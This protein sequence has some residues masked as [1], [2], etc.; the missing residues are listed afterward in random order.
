MNGED[1]R[2]QAKAKDPVREEAG[3]HPPPSPPAAR[4]RR[5]VKPPPN[6]ITAGGVDMARG[7][8]SGIVP[9]SGGS[10]EPV[11]NQPRVVLTVDTDMRRAPTHKGIVVERALRERGP[12]S[13]RLPGQGGDFLREAVRRGPARSAPS[14]ASTPDAQPPGPPPDPQKQLPVWMRVAFA[15]VLLL[16]LAGVAQRFRSAPASGR[17]APPAPAFTLA[18]LPLAEPLPAPSATP[19]TAPS[20]SVT[21]SAPPAA[22]IASA[23]RLPRPAQAAPH[24]PPASPPKPAFMPPFQLPGEKN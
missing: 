10:R 7:H 12:R 21:A 18:E 6:I 23:A 16:L 8:A 22:S 2:G 11:G 4:P 9:R 20:V 14:L 13:A 1:E 5:K 24:P 15:A 3:A 17:G 19:V